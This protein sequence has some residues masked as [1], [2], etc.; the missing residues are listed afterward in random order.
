[1]IRWSM[2]ASVAVAEVS[3]SHMATPNVPLE[4][5]ALIFVLKWP[6]K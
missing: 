1:M 3:H 6:Q 2:S 5:A 4:A